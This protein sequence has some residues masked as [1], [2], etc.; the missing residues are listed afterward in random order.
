[1]LK[2]L[3][4]VKVNNSNASKLMLTLLPLM[5]ALQMLADINVANTI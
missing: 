3:T 1:M 5:L 2:L 4:Q